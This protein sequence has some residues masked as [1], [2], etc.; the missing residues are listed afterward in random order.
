MTSTHSLQDKQT[1]VLVNKQSSH[2]K[3]AV[4]LIWAVL[5]LFAHDRASAKSPTMEHYTQNKRHV[6]RDAQQDPGYETTSPRTG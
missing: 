1:S 4:A 5:E 3:P 2:A 6:P